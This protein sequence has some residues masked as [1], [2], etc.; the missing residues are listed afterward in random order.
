MKEKIIPQR[1]TCECGNEVLNHHWLCDK[2]WGIRA[3]DKRVKEKK[4]QANPYISMKVGITNELLFLEALIYLNELLG[5]KGKISINNAG[6]RIL[7]IDELEEKQK[8]E[9]E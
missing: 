6:K 1:K 5:E 3:K 7:M 4:R 9:G 2:C 8:E